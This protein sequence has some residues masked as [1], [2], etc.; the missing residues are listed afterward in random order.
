MSWFDILLVM[1]VL[2]GVTA[3]TVII[4]RNP[5]F[6]WDFAAAGVLAAM[7]Y[8]MKRNTPEVEQEMQKCIRMGG[9]WDNFN[10]TCRFK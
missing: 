3:G 8:F 6:W 2:V 7:P 10:K 4:V 1:A 9:E 5:K